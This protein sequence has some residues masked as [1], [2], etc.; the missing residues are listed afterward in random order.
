MLTGK[1]K[2]DHIRVIEKHHLG[3]LRIAY[4]TYNKALRVLDTMRGEIPAPYCPW[5]RLPDEEREKF[6]VEYN[7]GLKRRRK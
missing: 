3:R 4:E 1:W 7:E 5:E 6:R 2:H